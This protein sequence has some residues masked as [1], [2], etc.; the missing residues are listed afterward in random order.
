MRLADLALKDVYG[1]DVNAHAPEFKSIKY[2]GDTATITLETYGRSLKT[3]GYAR[4]F[5][6][7]VNGV[8]INANALLEK[9]KLIVKSPECSDITGVRYLWKNW[10][11]PDVWLYNEDG[12]PAFSFINLK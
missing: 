2:E 3:K 1:K 6:V 7:K 11:T 8:W 5:E 10:A 12:L 4:G 9:G